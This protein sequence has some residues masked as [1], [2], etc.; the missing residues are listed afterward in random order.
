MKSALKEKLLDEVKKGRIIGPFKTAPVKD[1]MISPICVIPK[2]DGKKYR[3]IFNLSHP[4]G[5]SVNDNI[6]EDQTS[7]TYCSVT[8]VA[9]WIVRQQG[10]WF[11][12]KADLSDAYRMVPIR[13]SDWKYLGMRLGNDLFIDRCLPMGAASSCAIFQ[14]ISNALA[15]I[16]MSTSPTDCT[17]FN[18]LD[19]FLFLGRSHTDCEISL[20]TFI[21][22]CNRIGIPISK[23]KTIPPNTNLVFLGVGIDSSKRELFIPPEKARRVL[24]DLKKFLS[25][26]TQRVK[27]WQSILGKLCHLSQ[28]VSS[29][30]AYLSSVYTSLKG[31]LSQHGNCYRTISAEA[32]E[33][34]EVWKKFLEQIPPTRHFRML[35]PSAPTMIIHTDASKTVGYGAVW[36]QEWFAGEWPQNWKTLNIAILETFPILAALY[37]W[38]EKAE[39]GTILIHTDNEAVVSVVNKLYSKDRGLRQLIKPLALHCLSKNIKLQATHIEGVSNIG[40]DMLSRGK[41]KEFLARFQHMKSTPAV[42]PINILPNNLKLPA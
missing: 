26:R 16:V 5:Q 10:T 7:V 8:D 38:E 21:D 31:I 25:K 40:P 1:L 22:L 4:K 33:D 35:T 18:Y 32:R 42:L 23:N 41:I 34:L 14:R 37:T 17:V 11:M 3:M 27:K 30:R 12:A 9:R 13:K 29:G 20:K 24:E 15:W 39:N 19:D 6:P 36:G 28:V 2:S